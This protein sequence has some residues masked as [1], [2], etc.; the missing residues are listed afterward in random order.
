[1]HDTNGVELATA[2]LA[3]DCTLHHDERGDQEGGAIIFLF[4]YS[5]SRYSVS[6]VIL[7]ELRPVARLRNSVNRLPNTRK[8]VTA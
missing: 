8:E 6:R 5:G 7:A 2:H 3:R 4:G 1:M